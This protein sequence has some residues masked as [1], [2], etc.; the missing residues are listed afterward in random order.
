VEGINYGEKNDRAERS[1]LAML[2]LIPTRRN[3]EEMK[4]SK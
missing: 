4:D 2:E 1:K 3:D